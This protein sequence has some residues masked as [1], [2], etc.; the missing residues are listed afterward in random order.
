MN[1]CARSG[2]FVIRVPKQ[3]LSSLYT[4]VQV[5]LVPMCYVGMQCWTRCVPYTQTLPVTRGA[6]RLDRIPTRRVGTRNSRRYTQVSAR[7]RRSGR[8]AGTQAQGGETACYS[9]TCRAAKLPS[10][11]ATLRTGMAL[12]TGIH[13][14]MTTFWRT[15]GFVYND[16]SRNLGTRVNLVNRREFNK[17][18]H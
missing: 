9:S 8:D 4:N 7:R 10:P 18:T 3:G 2:S 5:H 12:D 13:A 14:G 15:T 16:E 11:S 17:W 6:A 1:A